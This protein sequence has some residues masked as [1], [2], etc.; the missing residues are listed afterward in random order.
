VNRTQ[1]S[2]LGFELRA[3]AASGESQ[4]AWFAPAPDGAPV[5]LKWFPDETVADRYAVL[6]PSL[7]KLRM[8]G[9]PVRSL[10]ASRARREANRGSRP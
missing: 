10:G 9:V 5:V 1:L 8:R 3:R 6:L 2:E 7:D 4:G